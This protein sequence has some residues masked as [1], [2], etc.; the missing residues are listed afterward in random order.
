VR[1]ELASVTLRLVFVQA[2]VKKVKKVV[3]LA[4]LKH[5]FYCAT[6]FGDARSAVS[7]ARCVVAHTTSRVY[8][9]KA[10]GGIR[11]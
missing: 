6:P 4:Q 9:K 2:Y 11:G 8:L 3:S 5:P 1:T 7:G 10:V